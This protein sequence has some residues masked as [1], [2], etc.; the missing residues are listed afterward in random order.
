MAAI[1]GWTSRRSLTEAVRQ[2]VLYGSGN[3]PY[4]AALVEGGPARVAALQSAFDLAVA[5]INDVLAASLV[6]ARVKLVMVV[7]IAMHQSWNKMRITRCR[8]RLVLSRPYPLQTRL[9]LCY[10]FPKQQLQAHLKHWPL[11]RQRSRMRPKRG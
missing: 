5:R 3:E 11:G 7:M 9:T 6:S 1:S 2:A 8:M 10:R 4:A